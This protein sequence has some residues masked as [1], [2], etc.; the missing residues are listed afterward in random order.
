MAQEPVE[1]A[2]NNE[3][4]KGSGSSPSTP[5]RTQS[6]RSSS[7]RSSY[8]GQ[9]GGRGPYRGGSGGGG[10]R[11]PRQQQGGQRPYQRRRFQRRK[12]C[13]FCADKTKVI[14]WKRTDELR[15]FV[16]D[17]GA[18]FPRRK[19]GMCAKHQRRVA[20]A[21]KRARHLA[22]FP[23]TTEHIRIMGKS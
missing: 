11:Y 18:I 2:K 17:S 4:T 1:K 16:D 9:G 10:G 22:L 13:A 8:S 6:G 19:S 23:Y 20:V 14:D 7:S 15:R 12:V 5:Q 3:G 21:I